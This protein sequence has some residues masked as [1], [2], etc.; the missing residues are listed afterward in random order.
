MALLALGAAVSAAAGAQTHVE[1]ILDASGSMY[2]KLADGRYRIS[3]AKDV[4]RAFV[5]NLPD[6]GLDVGLRIYGSELQS[7]ADGSCR[8]SKLFVPMRGVDRAALLE[9]LTKTRAR[10]STPIAYSL[11]QAARDF[12]AGVGRCAII[13]VTDGE[14]VCGGDLAASAARLEQLGCDLD[15][16]IIGFDLSPEAIASFEGIGTFE[17]ATDAAALAAALDRAAD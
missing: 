6:Q 9:T 10:G 13:L 4:L 5:E 3:A 12:P 2:N 16:R 11:E 17:N 1:I 7:N 8:D 14:E 15:L